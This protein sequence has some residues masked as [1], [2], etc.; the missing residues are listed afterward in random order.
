MWLAIYHKRKVWKKKQT[1]QSWHMQNLFGLNKRL[2]R[3]ITHVLSLPKNVWQFFLLCCPAGSLIPGILQARTKEWV[4]ISF[5]NAWKWEVKVKSLSCVWLLATPWTSAHQAPP[6]MGFSRQ[7]YWSGVPLP[8]PVPEHRRRINRALRV[9]GIRVLLS[10][11]GHRGRDPCCREADSKWVLWSMV[12]HM[13][14]LS[15]QMDALA[16]GCS[17]CRFCSFH[18]NKANIS[19]EKH[20][21]Q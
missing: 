8:S 21:Y 20:W 6:S 12:G 2:V 5:S 4:A 10:V 1:L 18:I 11:S 17:S 15:G 19:L 14:R 7:E 3:L 9:R 13:G 16:P